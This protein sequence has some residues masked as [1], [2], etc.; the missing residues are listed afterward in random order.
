[1]GLLGKLL[2]KD[3]KEKQKEFLSSMG[4]LLQSSGVQL[5]DIVRPD[6]DKPQT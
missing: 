5:L 2:A 6:G 4:Q 1:M 3:A